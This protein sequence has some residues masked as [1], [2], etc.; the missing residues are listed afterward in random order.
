MGSQTLQVHRGWEVRNFHQQNTFLYQARKQNIHRMLPLHFT[1][2]LFCSPRLL[3]PQNFGALCGCAPRTTSM[4]PLL[5]SVHNC[6][7]SPE[8]ASGVN[9]THA[10]TLTL[11][12][13]NWSNS[14]TLCPCKEPL[15]GPPIFYE[16]GW[17]PQPV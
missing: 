15:V 6:V 1:I 16:A 7:P 2:E 12:G 3:V 10:I 14:A 9:Y 11:D 8:H 4:P 17:A 5:V 13:S